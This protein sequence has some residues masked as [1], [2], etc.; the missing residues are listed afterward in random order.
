MSADVRVE[1]RRATDSRKHANGICLVT[2]QFPGISR[3]TQLAR[4][5]EMQARALAELGEVT[6][7]FTGKEETRETVLRDGLRIV[8]LQAWAKKYRRSVLNTSFWPGTNSVKTSYL[9]LEYLKARDFSVVYFQDYLG[10]GFRSFQ[11]KSCGLGLSRSSLVLYVHGPQDWK[12]ERL[13]NMAGSFDDLI[14][15]F[16]EEQCARLADRIVTPSKALKEWMISRWGMSSRAITI[17]PCLRLQGYP[18]GNRTPTFRRRNIDRIRV[19]GPSE[20]PLEAEMV[21][22]AV[23]E[24]PFL[25][26]RIKAVEFIC[27]WSS[28]STR[29]FEVYLE[30]RRSR[31]RKAP[32][33][34]IAPIDSAPEQDILKRSS[35]TLFILP[36]LSETLTPELALL[37][38]SGLP[39]L[40]SDAAAS[41]HAGDS[42]FEP[43]WISLRE[44]IERMVR[45]EAPSPHPSAEAAQRPLQEHLSRLHSELARERKRRKE[46]VIRP[47]AGRIDISVIIPHYNAAT[48]LGFCLD[49]MKKQRKAAGFEIIV[50][51]D[52]SNADQLRKLQKLVALRNSTGLSVKLISLPENKGPSNARNV[53]A[54]AARGKYL[55]FFDAD[56]E[57]L[58]DMLHV[59]LTALRSTGAD[60]LTCYRR[61]VEQDDQ[62][63]LKE[64]NFKHLC[65]PL[66]PA[67]APG[68]LEN[69]YGDT[70]CVIR[71]KVFMDRGGFN[72]AR[73][74]LVDFED[75]DFFSSLALA[76]FRLGVIPQEL[77][78][79][80]RT[81]HGYNF[82]TNL[83]LN[84][85]RIIERYASSELF[86]TSDGRMLLEFL[87][88]CCRSSFMPE[89]FVEL[90]GQGYSSRP[91]FKFFATLPDDELASY[92]GIRAATRSGSEAGKDDDLIEMRKRLAPLAKEWA[93]KGK[94]IYVY[95]AGQHTKVLLGLLPEL[96][97]LV[98]KIIDRSDTTRFLG[99]KC[100]RPDEYK[101]A[102]DDIILYSSRIHAA[103]M[104][105]NMWQYDVTHIFPYEDQ[106]REFFRWAKR[107]R[108]AG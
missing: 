108:R 53:G 81:S 2:P 24:S 77:V 28:L 44:R 97:E 10:H 7:L 83:Y 33:C 30:N 62:K 15:R 3:P 57:A 52:S 37:M 104:A 27:G 50:V 40:S 87:Q 11:Y 41:E 85:S 82:R 73:G 26:S 35:S 75:W 86:R 61:I 31:S 99:F 94:R 34:S 8:N 64:S 51:D 22:R 6:V 91:V 100:I 106:E 1:S 19:L 49:S 66:G 74:P 65:A 48:R 107:T 4:R 78:L 21:I 39:F 12:F 58:P 70:T 36:A 59:M 56:N 46:K 13:E 16:M 102:R 55:V 63:P 88:N 17:L 5:V 25:C 72:T 32:I 23:E 101:H 80:R 98:R 90:E 38:E 54:D 93:A 84:Y 103:K 105:Q 42:Y 92:L 95:G 43:D 69:V 96:A 45:G 60:C 89:R 14:T 79:Y 71:K 68:F 29:A 67:I 47:K 76:N 9:A 20:T 18:D